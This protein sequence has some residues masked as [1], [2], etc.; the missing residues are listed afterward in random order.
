M[1]VIGIPGHSRV[2]KR[3]QLGLATATEGDRELVVVRDQK[4]ELHG[5]FVVIVRQCT[6]VI[7]GTC[8]IGRNQA[9]AYVVLSDRVNRG[10]VDDGA[11]CAGGVCLEIW[12]GL[13]ESR[14][15]GIGV[16]AVA[17]RASAGKISSQLSGGVYRAHSGRL[18]L[19][20]ALP[21]IAD[22]KEGFVLLNGAAEGGA[23]LIA[24]EH[25]SGQAVRVVKE[26]VGVEGVIAQKFK[27]A[28]VPSIG[29]GLGDHADDAAAVPTVFGRV[30]ALEEAK[31]GDGVG[32]GVVDDAVVE[33]VVVECAVEK[34]RHRVGTAAGD[35]VV[36]RGAAIVVGFGDSGQ[37]LRQ[38]KN[39]AT[40]QRGTLDSFSHDA[41]AD[42][43]IDGL[44]VGRLTRHLDDLVLLADFETGVQPQRLVNLKG[45]V[46]ESLLAESGHLNC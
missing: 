24:L 5:Q 22:E 29:A 40:I 1:A 36:T 32:I 44:D 13:Q 35:A 12:I 23:V 18:L 42:R 15:V 6:L 28:A 33:Q 30:V 41:C 25:V 26:S 8:G 14:H 4:I 17:R 31:L 38:I 3:E 11:S 19:G 9:L 16:G 37:E 34:K 43:L 39:V 21:L 45:L 7:V 46:L 27:G 2:I 10:G 20:E